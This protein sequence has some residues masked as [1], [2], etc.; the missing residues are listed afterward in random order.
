MI[1]LQCDALFADLDI[2]QREQSGAL[3]TDWQ[4]VWKTPNPPASSLLSTLPVR[5]LN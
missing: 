4:I 5:Y 2:A 3:D 1:R